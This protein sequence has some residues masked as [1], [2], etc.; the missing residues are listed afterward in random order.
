MWR[1]GVEGWGG[2]REAV[3]FFSLVD[4]EKGLG[5]LGAVV[6]WFSGSLV[7]SCRMSGHE[8][9]VEQKRVEVGPVGRWW[10]WGP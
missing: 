1:A 9:R 2:G 10:W 8:R 4:A 3:A 5:A 6:R 7:F